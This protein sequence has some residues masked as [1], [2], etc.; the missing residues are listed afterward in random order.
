[1]EKKVSSTKL[2]TVTDLSPILGPDFKRQRGREG[3][4]VGGRVVGKVDGLR[5]IR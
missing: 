3:R 2:K 5:E 1:M 4:K